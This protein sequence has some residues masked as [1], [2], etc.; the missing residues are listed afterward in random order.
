[1]KKA[2]SLLLVLAMML[3]LTVS[4]FADSSVGRDGKTIYSESSTV[5]AGDLYNELL[6]IYGSLNYSDLVYN[7][8]RAGSGL[9]AN[10]L[11][12]FDID[13][14]TLD[15]NG[16]SFLLDGTTPI[17]KGSR[18]TVELSTGTH[19]VT[20]CFNYHADYTY[21]KIV[22]LFGSDST[23]S[24]DGSFNGNAQSFNFSIRYKTV[25]KT[26]KSSV[27]YQYG[28]VADPAQYIMD[29]V[30]PTVTLKD[31]TQVG[32]AADV[33]IVENVSK[34]NAGIHTITLSYAGK[35][36]GTEPGYQASTKEILVTVKAIPTSIKVDS[37]LIKYDG[38]EHMP[39]ITVTPEGIPYTAVT[40]GIQGDAVGF[41][42]LYMSEGNTVYKAL[43]F[44]RDSNDTLIRIGKLLGFDV[45]DFLVGSD[46]LSLEQIRNLVKRLNEISDVLTRA[47]IIVEES[48][49][50]D[51]LDTLDAIGDVMAKYN[52]NAKFY[53]GNFP[54]NQGLYDT[55]AV[56]SEPN[57]ETSMADGITTIYRDYNVSMKWAQDAASYNFTKDS[58]KKFNFKAFVTN[59][60]ST[61]LDDAQISYSFTGTTADGERFTSDSLD[62]L[63]TVP[64]TY[65]QTA[66]CTLNY[67]ASATRSFTINKYPA[68][69]KFVDANGKYVDTVS[70]DTQYDGQAKGFTAVVVDANGKVIDGASVTYTYTGTTKAGAKYNS[71]SAP[72]DSGDYTLKASFAGNSDYAAASNSSATIAIHKAAASISFGNITSRI[73]QKVDYSKVTYTYTGMTAEE[74]AQI[75][76][77]LNCGSRIHLLIGSHQMKVTVPSDISAKYDVTVNAGTHTVKLFG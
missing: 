41:A 38:E 35:D 4:A 40:V 9:R 57:Y 24:Y 32:T 7:D 14:V 65:K 58:V 42:S 68:F 73:L 5:I 54:K 10:S 59:D 11:V 77:T 71:S 19:S 74:A 27:S 60:G 34:L 45:S 50:N 29:T 75:A 18:S 48:Q 51:L 13:N 46:G 67:S 64:G 28:S 62:N 30:A 56:I 8:V 63:P 66:K 44:I 22:N 49:I 47:G 12:K 17:T 36:N 25:I 6:A 3:S 33:K 61:P 26:A 55:H 76:S 39:N 1:M 16:I 23:D 70:I 15:A 31:G 69:V 20:V 43:I 52:V 37:S 2:L 72:F 53:I 21:K